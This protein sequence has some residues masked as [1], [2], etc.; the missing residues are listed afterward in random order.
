[1]N[2]AL[3]ANG[4]WDYPADALGFIPGITLDLNQP[5]WAIRYGCERFRRAHVFAC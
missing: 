3:M 1:M 5:G 4:A 2:W